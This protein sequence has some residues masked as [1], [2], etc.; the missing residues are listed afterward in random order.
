MTSEGLQEGSAQG[1]RLIEAPFMVAKAGNKRYTG[2]SWLF[3]LRL[4]SGDE[5]MCHF[6]FH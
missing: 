5:D 3:S 6:H 4:P 2:Y 1:L